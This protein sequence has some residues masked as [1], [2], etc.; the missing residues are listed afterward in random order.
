MDRGEANDIGEGPQVSIPF[1]ILSVEM[2]VD[3]L[4]SEGCFNM[5]MRK[6]T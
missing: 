3:F 6:I 1:I 4:C 5:G 2:A